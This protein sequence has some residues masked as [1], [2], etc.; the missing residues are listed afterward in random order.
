MWTWA[1]Q[2][3]CLNCIFNFITYL[4]GIKK[5]LPC[6]PNSPMYWI[7]QTFW[8]YYS[9]VI[10]NLEW[11]RQY[12][13]HLVQIMHAPSPRYS[14]I[15]SLFPLHR[16]HKNRNSRCY[17]LSGISMTCL[18]ES[19]HVII[20]WL[21]D[22]DHYMIT[23]LYHCLLGTG[24]TAEGRQARWGSPQRFHPQLRPE[25]CPLPQG[26]VEDLRMQWGSRLI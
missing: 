11:V 8:E 10:I 4:M 13:H 18:L 16:N 24:N 3:N 9:S 20:G 22:S 14:D 25:G 21:H 6:L 12:Q 19:T 26:Q 7:H 23:A 15:H 2:L 17:Q 1:N 5:Q